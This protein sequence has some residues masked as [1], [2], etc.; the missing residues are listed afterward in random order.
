MAEIEIGQHARIRLAAHTL[1]ELRTVIES[2]RNLPGETVI[3]ARLV[4]EMH[5]DGARISNLMLIPPEQLA[6]VTEQAGVDEL[7]RRRKKP[8][9]K[10]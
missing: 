4:F 5:R 1:H 7:N 8:P 6:E 3:R 2:T 10:R 9:R